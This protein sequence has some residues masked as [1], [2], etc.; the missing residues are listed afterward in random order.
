MNILNRTNNSISKKWLIIEETN[1][2][3]SVGI[4]IYNMFIAYYYIE[5]KIITNFLGIED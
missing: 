4:N 5:Q 3:N 2:T 1:Q